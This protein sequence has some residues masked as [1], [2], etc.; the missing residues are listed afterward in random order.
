MCSKIP[1]AFT[2]VWRCARYLGVFRRQLRAGEHYTTLLLFWFYREI[3]VIGISNLLR[4]CATAHV[5]FFV[6]KNEKVFVHARRTARRP[7]SKPI[8]RVVSRYVPSP[9]CPTP[10]DGV[11]SKAIPACSPNW[12]ANWVTFNSPLSSIF[13]LLYWF[14]PPPL[15]QVWPALKSKNSG[16]W[17]TVC[18][19][20]SSESHRESLPR[21]EYSNRYRS[22]YRPVHGLIFLFRWI[23]E[24]QPD[25]PIVKDS[26]I[27]KI[28]FAQQVRSSGGSLRL[29]SVQC[30]DYVGTSKFI[31]SCS[32]H[33]YIV[34]N[35]E[36][37]SHH[38]TEY[39]IQ[40]TV[41]K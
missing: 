16:R 32:F 1:I 21:D 11:W 38:D 18:S 6:R 9:P 27:E 34:F 36:M 26:R 17:T 35:Y 15:F 7:T 5:F 30:N 14:F 29:Y 24:D 28:F 3:T 33:R 41:V 8:S 13:G 10:R 25:G 19:T 12:S 22:C 23:G 40:I 31:V 39:R 20:R 4:L 2:A 37:V